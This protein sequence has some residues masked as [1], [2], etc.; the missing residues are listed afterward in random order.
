MWSNAL[1]QEAPAPKEEL[2][3][4]DDLFERYRGLVPKR[5]IDYWRYTKK[6]PA[7]HQ[8]RPARLVSSRRG[9]RLGTEADDPLRPGEQ[10]ARLISRR[11]PSAQGHSMLRCLGYPRVPTA[12]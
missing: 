3:T 9:D 1:R 4:V 2:L 11:P 7:V 10:T 6:G 5:T 8:N 12:H